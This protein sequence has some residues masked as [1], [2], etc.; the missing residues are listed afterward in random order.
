MAHEPSLTAETVQRFA[1]EFLNLQ[2]DDR[3]AEYV[4]NM[5]NNLNDDLQ[6][7][8]QMDVGSAE[9]ATPAIFRDRDA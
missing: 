5:L 2:V 7:M 3:D 9:P 4:S 6:P 1:A 8:R